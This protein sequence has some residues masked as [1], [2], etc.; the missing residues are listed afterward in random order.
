MNTLK[1]NKPLKDKYPSLLP[2]IHSKQCPSKKR[3]C[4]T[5]RLEI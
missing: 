1:M 5:E 2:S 4:S 3:E